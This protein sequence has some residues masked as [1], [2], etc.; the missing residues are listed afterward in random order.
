ML[1]AQ[2]SIALE[3]AILAQS[4]DYYYPW[5]EVIRNSVLPA[6]RYL[7]AALGYGV[8]L[9]AATSVIAATLHV[10]RIAVFYEDHQRAKAKVK[11]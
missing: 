1:S 11:S 4:W 7:G 8:F 3:Y 10:L 9:Y 2:Q 5:P 6:A